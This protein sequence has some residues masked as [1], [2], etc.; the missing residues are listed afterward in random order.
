MRFLRRVRVETTSIRQ[1][2]SSCSRWGW[3][4]LIGAGWAT[5]TEYAL[6]CTHTAVGWPR[7]SS[8]L[9]TQLAV[10]AIQL[11]HTRLHQ[12]TCGGMGSHTHLIDT[13]TH[14]MTCKHSLSRDFLFADQLLARRREKASTAGCLARVRDARLS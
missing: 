3:D 13:L 2:G 1:A 12:A 14:T 4:H 5:P 11:H 10:K 6:R 9:R 7:G 8:G